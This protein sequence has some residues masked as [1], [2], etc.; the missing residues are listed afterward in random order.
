MSDYDKSETYIVSLNLTRNKKKISTMVTPF[1]CEKDIA[2][3]LRY[4]LT[5]DYTTSMR[6]HS[7]LVLSLAIFG[8]PVHGDRSFW[9]A[10]PVTHG[11]PSSSLSRSPRSRALRNIQ[12]QEEGDEDNTNNKDALVPSDGLNLRAGGQK[13]NI[14]YTNV[15]QTFKVVIDIFTTTC[16]VVLPPVVAAGQIVAGVYRTLPKDAIMAQAGLVYC[17]AGGYFPTLF[18]AVSAAQH[19]G[20]QVMMEAT[21]DLVDEACLAIDAAATKSTKYAATAREVFQ[22]KTLIVLATIDPVKINQAAGALY[23]TWMGVASVLE[24]EFARTISLSITIADYLQPITRVVIAPPIYMVVPEEYHQWVPVCVG[25]ACKAAAMSLA[26]RVQRVITASSSSI[27]GGLMFSRALL[28]MASKRVPWLKR[29]KDQDATYLDE[30][31]G[32]L[33]AGLGLYSQIGN[34]FKFEVPFP[35][36]LVTWPFEVAERCIQWSIT[37]DSKDV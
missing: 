22:Q 35:I 26:W 28:R 8:A 1:S 13:K 20:I 17:F 14:S 33:V 12:P 27:A 32:L 7:L 6:F 9:S 31:V 3:S 5:L 11:A 25:W 36:N 23:V 18:A 15:E 19:C 21:G 2:T 10:R 16:S 30:I 29:S 4:K 24:R 37:K 34:G